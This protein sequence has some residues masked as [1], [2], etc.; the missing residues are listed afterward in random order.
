M[1][2]WLLFDLLVSNRRWMLAAV[3][4]AATLTAASL[5]SKIN[6]LSSV[7]R[8]TVFLNDYAD[9]AFGLWKYGGEIR[10]ALHAVAPG[11]KLI[12]N[13]DGMY[14]Y[15]LDMPAE[16]VTGLVSSPNELRRRDQL[17]FW[18]SALS[19]GFTLI[20]DF[21]YMKLSDYTG[22][23]E[24]T[25]VYRHPIVQVTFYQVRLREN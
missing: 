14:G 15:L 23:I 11:A 13:L 19:R 2:V 17:G 1:G 5:P 12:D 10:D 20:G 25:A 9:V 4:V 24:A 21:G 6:E 18:P 7:Q 3:M 22:R 8:R 16:T